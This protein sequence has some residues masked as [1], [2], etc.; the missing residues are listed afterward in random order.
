MDKTL[1]AKMSSLP[2]GYH[3]HRYCIT[4]EDLETFKITQQWHVLACNE[5][6]NGL[7]F[8]NIVEHKRF[9]YKHMVT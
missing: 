3:F 6:D 7:E 5:D 8:I 1:K 4:K 2:F 9:V